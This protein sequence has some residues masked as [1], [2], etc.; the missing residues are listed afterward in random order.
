[1]LTKRCILITF[2]DKSFV[3]RL[4]IL[5]CLIDVGADLPLSYN[6]SMVINCLQNN[7]FQIWLCRD[8]ISFFLH[9]FTPA[10]PATDRLVVGIL[11]AKVFNQAL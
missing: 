8:R 1:M 3:D 10:T 2:Q 9:F 4:E 7:T 5:F 6:Y 11:P